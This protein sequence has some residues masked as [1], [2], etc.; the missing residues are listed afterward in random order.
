MILSFK[1]QFKKKILNGDKIH[2][3]REDK[4]RRWKSG[5]KIHFATGVRTKKQKQFKEGVCLSVQRLQICPTCVA[6]RVWVGDRWL[7]AQEIE[8][9]ARNDGFKNAKEFFKWFD[10]DFDGVLIHWTNYKY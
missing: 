5:K 3:I 8:V 10:K 4:K 2:T 7:Q 1:K 9:L 6:L